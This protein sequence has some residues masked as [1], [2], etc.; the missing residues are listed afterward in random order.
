MRSEQL[1]RVSSVL[2][3]DETDFAENPQSPESYILQ[4]ADRS[5]YD[6]ECSGFTSHVPET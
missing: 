6:V 1:S 3:G 5:S 4:V 2:C